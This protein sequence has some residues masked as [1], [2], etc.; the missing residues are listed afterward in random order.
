MATSD[1]DMQGRHVMITGCTAG[2][3]RAAAIDL[4]H[5][6]ADLS[7]VCRSREK[8]EALMSEL[9]SGGVPGRTEVWIADMGSQRDIRN[10]AQKFLQLDRPLHVLFNNAGVVLQKRTL[11]EEGFETTFAVNH[12]GY[13]LLTLLL[14]DRLKAS[15][16]ARVVNTASGAHKFA[17]G[18]LDFDNLQSEKRYRTMK[19]YGASKLAN[20]L[21]TRELARRLS[22]TGVTANAFHP[23][24]VGSDFAK[25]NGVVAVV[26]M[27]LLRPFARS[28]LKGAETGIYL[29]TEPSLQN[30]SGGYY[31]DCTPLDPAPSGRSDEDA[32]R[33]WEVSEQL[34]GATH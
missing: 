20:I 9:E 8:G 6:G 21:F 26:A 25:N 34:V 12:L 33:L 32:A 13:F 3:G 22:G 2:L 30:E 23:G 18:R 31:H 7:L 14:T 19:T 28:P 5:R 17:G 16:P 4:A 1:L 27:N 15:G 11:T 24:M 10:L 29:C